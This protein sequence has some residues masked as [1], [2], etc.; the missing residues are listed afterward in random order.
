MTVTRDQLIKIL[1]YAR[2]KASIFIDPLN[3]AMQEFDINTAARQA[4]FIAQCGHESGS[5][6]YMEELASGTA[7]EGRKDLGNVQK[8]DG[9]R[10]KG[11]GI[12]QI[13]G[14]ANYLECSKALFGDDRLI[15]FPELLE[16]PAIACRSAGWFWKS[17]GLN[18]LADVGDFKRITKK[19]NG[20]YNGMEDRLAHYQRALAT[21]P[22]V[23]TN[24]TD[25]RTR[26]A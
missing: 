24:S 6:V 7:Y 11:R 20:G 15:Q 25:G 21:L 8:G 4:A 22:P 18:E 1:P 26:H 16:D 10:F 13:T 9:V 23:Y 12:I 14:R 19:I 5:F 17:R 2:Q 3:A